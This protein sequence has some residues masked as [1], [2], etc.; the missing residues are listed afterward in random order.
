MSTNIKSNYHSLSDELMERI[1]DDRAN[2]VK[3]PYACKDTDI[4]RRY[5]GHDKPRLW[6]PSFVMDVEKILHNNYY[7]RYSDKTQVISCYKNDDISRRALHVQLVSRIARTIGMTLGLNLDLIE[8]IS[9]GHDIGHTPFGHA[10]ERFLNELYNERTGRLFNHN[11]HSVRVLDKLICRNVSLQVLDGVICHNGEL[12]QQEFRPKAFSIDTAWEDFDANVAACYTNPAA[13]REQIPGTLEGCVMR[14]SDIIAYLGK[15]RQ[16]A[17]KL[18]LFEEDPDYEISSIGTTNAEIINNISVNIMENSYGQNYLKMDDQYFE[19]L[20]G[21]KKENYRRIYGNEKL[22]AVYREQISPMF[23][24]IYE[25]LL[26][27][28]E[29][30]DRSSVIF[31]HHMDYLY[32]MTHYYADFAAYE[33]EDANDIVV[34]YMASMTDDYFI[35]LYHY[36]FPK[37]RYQVSYVGYFDHEKKMKGEI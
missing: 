24:D 7:N 17:M 3:N 11:V 33:A 20:K 22:E 36:L 4:I 10:G 9:L 26:S 14:I 2:H 28:Y 37:G 15:D 35:D 34:D 16:D 32:D 1:S 23:R 5:N 8:A 12:V 6:R 30:K 13:N 29:K 21:S 25:K 31:T 27:D 18:G 19:A